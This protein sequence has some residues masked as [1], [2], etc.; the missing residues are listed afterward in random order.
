MCMK[1]FAANYILDKIEFQTWPS[2]FGS[3]QDIPC[4]NCLDEQDFGFDCNSSLPVYL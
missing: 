1:T 2:N 3:L 4:F